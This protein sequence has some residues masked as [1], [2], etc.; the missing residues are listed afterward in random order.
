[1]ENWK[2]HTHYNEGALVYDPDERRRRCIETHHSTDKF[3][4]KKW[5]KMDKLSES[6]EMPNSKFAAIT[7]MNQDYYN[8]CGRAM[9]KSFKA[10]WSNTMPLYVYNEDN[11]HVK[12]KSIIPLGWDLGSEYQAFQQRHGNPKIRIFSKKAFSIIHAMENIECDRL[13]WLDADTLFVEDFNTQLLDMIAPDDVLSTHFSVWHQQNDITYHSCETGFFILNKKHKGFHEFKDT[14]SQIY[15]KDK[16]DGLRRFYDG[17]VY[18]KTVELMAARGH[19][20]MN[21][22]PGKHK[23]PFSRSVIGPYIQ[24]FKAG[25]KDRINFDG[26]EAELETDD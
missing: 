6:V 1:M 11:F 19:K 2:P 14:Y 18:G 23:T 3:D 16:T 20:M 10:H 24:H 5:K 25:L 13:I 8:H 7:S 21:L 22:N 9:L 17:E 12:V 26:L 15:S 4:D